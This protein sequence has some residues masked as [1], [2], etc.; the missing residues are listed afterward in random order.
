MN[1]ENLLIL[2]GATGTEL[3]KKGMPAG[4]CTEEWILNN[5][6]IFCEIQKAYVLSG[7]QAVYAPTFGAN[8]IKLKNSKL[9]DDVYNTNMRL[10]ALS[11]KAVGNNVYI[12]GDISPVGELLEPLGSLTPE[13]LISAYK[14]QFKAFYDFS[15]DF[16]IAE[17]MMDIREV[18]CALLAFEEIYTDKKCP[19]FVS[20]T[21]E[22]NGKTLTGTDPLTAMLLAEY[23][24]A[25]A[26]GLNCSTGPDSMLGIFKEIYPYSKIPLIVKPNA[27]LPIETENGLV[28]SMDAKKFGECMND[29]VKSGA[30][31]LGGCCGTTPEYVKEIS[32]ISETC[33]TPKKNIRYASSLRKTVILDENTEIIKISLSDDSD[34]DDLYYDIMDAEIAELSVDCSDEKLSALLAQIDM[35]VFTPIIFDAPVQKN[36]IITANYTGACYL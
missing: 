27:G 5:P 12:G 24:G 10:L 36:N 30:K 29:L 21:L 32:N 28:F 15:V 8:K 34:I 26:F 11:R 23:Y 2:D 6:E 33:N 22:T 9:A 31:I 1:F 7:S 17:T 35:T 3:M 20:M 18:K 4:V 25:D 13:K 19:F 16:I 14:E